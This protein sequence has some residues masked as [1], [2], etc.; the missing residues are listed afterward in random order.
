[1]GAYT[2]SK[3]VFDRK[4][5]DVFWC[6]ADVGWVTGHSYVVYGPLMCGATVFMYEGAPDYPDKDRMWELVERHQ[7]SVFYTAPAA[8][9]AFMKWGTAY[10]EKHDLSSLRLLGSVG[11][12][13]NPEAWM[14]YHTH[15]GCGLLAIA[16]TIWGDDRYVQT[17]FSRWHEPKLYFPGDGA[18]RDGNGHF[19]ILGRIDDALNVCGHRIGTMEVESALVDHPAVEEAAVVG[20]KHD[21]K[22]QAIVAFVSL[23]GNSRPDPTVVESL[24]TEYEEKYAT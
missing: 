5:E 20:R 10:P 6:A 21:I 22:G 11:E 9:R 15:I 23:K 8:I 18:K 3:D 19:M 13:I 4:E 7:V 1:M 17:Y 24:R 12:P 14:W 16:R 2:T